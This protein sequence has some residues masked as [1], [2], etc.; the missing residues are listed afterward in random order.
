MSTSEN[1]L[2]HGAVHPR[3]E[4]SPSATEDRT[5]LSREQRSSELHARPVSN[6]HEREQRRSRGGA[7]ESRDV[8]LC[9]CQTED[10]TALGHEQRTHTVQ[11]H[12]ARMTR[13]Q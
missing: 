12:A 7:P 10:C 13:Q 9:K 6:E 8:A 3:A 1:S 11:Q 2:G 5:A 4:T